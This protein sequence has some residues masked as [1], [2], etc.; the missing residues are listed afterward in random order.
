MFAGNTGQVWVLVSGSFP[1]W[2][3]L[4]KVSENKLRTLKLG[5][6]AK[7]V[8][9]TAKTLREK[10]N[11][12]NSLLNLSYED[13]K[14]ELLT[15]PGIGAKIADCVLLFWRRFPSSF[16][17][18]HMDRKILGQTIFSQKDGVNLRKL[19]L[20]KYTLV[21]MPDWLNNFCFLVKD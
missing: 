18:G 2:E 14:N 16:S 20:P 17:D 7:Y 8:F 11:W 6:R 21:I 9:E 10:P 15:L 13:A 1:G 19:I 4:A 3:I 12:L 5:Y